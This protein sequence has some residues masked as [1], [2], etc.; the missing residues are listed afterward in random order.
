MSKLHQLRVS[1]GQFST[2]GQRE[3]NQD[4]HGAIV[5]SDQLIESKGIAVALSDGISSSK[6]S[7]VA[8]ETA[9]K[10]FL[11][12]YYCTPEAWTVRTSAER[13]LNATNSWLYAQTRQSQFRYEQDRGYVCTFSGMIFKSASA[14]LFHVGDSRIYRCRNGELKL[15]TRD[16]RVSVAQEETLL[17]RAMGFEPNVEIDNEV[18]ALAAGDRFLFMTDGA[19]ESLDSDILSELLNSTDELDDVCRSIVEYSIERGSQDNLTAQIIR[20]DALPKQT[21]ED[22]QQS[23]TEMPFPS[24]LKVGANFDGFSILRQLYASSRSHVYMATDTETKT[25]VVIKIPAVE[26]QSDSDHLERFVTEEWIA[27]RVNN[28]HVVNGFTED[29]KRNYLYSV[30]EYIEGQ[31]LGQWMRDHEAPSLETVR[32]MVEQIGK[33]LQSFHRLE[34]LH[35]DLRPENLMIDADG[36]ITII[37]FGSTRVAG[38]LENS[39]LLPRQ[40]ALG[41]HQYMAPEYLLGEPGTTASDIYSLGVITYQLITGE[42]PYGA[43][44]AQ[45]RTKVGQYRVQ[46]KSATHPN[47]EL[48]R[49]IDE[50]L[51]KAVH[52]NP[53]HRYWE[54]SEFLYDLRN[55]RQEF[56]NIPPLIERDPALFWKRVSFFLVAVLVGLICLLVLRQST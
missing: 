44:M 22:L 10:A 45:A 8:S 30:T 13:V 5:P 48:P 23:L 15:L 26:M 4:C 14:H 56:L 54:I 50:T 49:W 7:Q 18:F 1:I 34:M 43:K 41:T 33:G 53:N 21:L 51:R 52:P 25:K 12:D 20:I 47:R 31:T 16:H 9:V 40:N 55:P 29:R 17:T 37:D 24:T 11:E 39:T 27:R 2:A 38:L 46:Y 28:P 32:Q 6:V 42:L 35:Q 19:Y 36:T 3:T